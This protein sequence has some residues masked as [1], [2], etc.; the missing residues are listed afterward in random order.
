VRLVDV[1]EK[2]QEDQTFVE[3]EGQKFRLK[4]LADVDLYSQ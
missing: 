1:E 2:K 4:I 3:G